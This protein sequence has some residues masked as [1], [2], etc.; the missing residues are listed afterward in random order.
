MGNVVI[1]GASKGI[2]KAVAELF[3]ANGFNLFLCS[4][5]EASL[6]KAMEDLLNKFPGVKIK[7]KPFD[8]SI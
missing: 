8:L 5:G 3:A 7:A 2:G 1:T 6:Y 4:R